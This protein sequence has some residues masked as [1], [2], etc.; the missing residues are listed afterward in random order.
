MDGEALVTHA[1]ANMMKYRVPRFSATQ[2]ETNDNTLLGGE[3][4]GSV[5]EA[6]GRYVAID[7]T[8]LFVDRH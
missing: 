8:R 5:S 1:G 6:G 4:M 2:R 3:L 7:E